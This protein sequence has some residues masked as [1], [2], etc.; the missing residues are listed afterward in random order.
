MS[1]ALQKLSSFMRWHLSILDLRVWGSGVLVRNFFPVPMSSR[2]FP[3][4]SSIWFTESGFMLRE[5]FDPLGIE[6]CARWQ[7]WVNF[8]FCTYR[9]PVRPAPFIE[10]AF[11]FPLYIFGFFVKDQVTISVWVFNSI[12]LIY[13]PVSVPIPCS[14]YY[15]CSVVQLGV[16]DG[17]SSSS[18]FIVQECFCYTGYFVFPYDVENCLTLLYQG[19]YA[20]KESYCPGFC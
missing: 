19:S 7:I 11:F 18:S 17:N 2:L 20:L 5:V 13:L 3:T 14:F 8:H 6:L 10:H 4:F 9:Q 16:R 15:Y 1:F 12:L